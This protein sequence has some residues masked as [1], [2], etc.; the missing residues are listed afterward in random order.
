[1]PIQVIWGNEE[2]TVILREMSGKWTWDEFFES[3]RTVNDMLEGIPQTIDQIF[4]VSRASAL[5]QGALTQ[6]RSA[7]NQRAYNSGLRVVVGPNRF[8][9]MMFAMLAKIMPHL[10]DSVV[11][12]E[13]MED[14]YQVIQESRNKVES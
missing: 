13:T 3:Q 4:D 8:Y 11:M 2:K 6:L 12:V 9:E 10:K 5:P 1:M 14:A 7:T